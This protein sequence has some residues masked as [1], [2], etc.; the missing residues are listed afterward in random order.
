MFTESS[1]RTGSD[2]ADR[3]RNKPFAQQALSGRAF[4]L[5]SPS[6]GSIEPFPFG[7]FAGSV[8][9]EMQFDFHRIVQQSDDLNDLVIRQ[10][11]ENDV[12]R[13]L[14]QTIRYGGALTGVEQMEA[15]KPWCNFISNAAADP[16]GS[17]RDIFQRSEDQILVS[18]PG[19]N[20][21]LCVGVSQDV[22]DV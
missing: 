21:E 20:T 2:E 6:I 16:V 4:T 7:S 10:P 15:S 1:T 5:D 9:G 22:H 19:G 3:G 14:D 11:I 8:L 18:L 17:G 13:S 12:P